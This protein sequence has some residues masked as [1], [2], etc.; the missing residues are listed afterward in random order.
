MARAVAEAQI[1]L[2]R[3]RHARF[4]L[5][6]LHVGQPQSEEAGN[7]LRLSP[8]DRITAALQDLAAPLMKMDRYERRAL[9][10]R[11]FAIRKLECLTQKS[12]DVIF[13][14]WVVHPDFGRTN[15]N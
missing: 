14:A 2:A 9:S 6:S 1:E 12:S 3:V 10:R 13:R 4:Q 11:K 15:P 5:L 7:R 8:E